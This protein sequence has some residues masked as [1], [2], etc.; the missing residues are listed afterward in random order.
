VTQSANQT[1]PLPGQGVRTAMLCCLVAMLDGLDMQMISFL[2]VA[3]MR[4]LGTSVV[5]FGLVFSAGLLGA[6]MGGLV[7]GPLSDLFGRRIVIIISTALFGTFALVT[8]A[9]GSS[10][11]LIALRFLTG[12][13]LGGALPNILALTAEYSPQNRRSMMVSLMI[14]GFPLGAVF[15]GIA[16]SALLDHQLGWRVIMF[17]GGL[18]PLI[19]IPILLWK[20]PESSEFL[21]TINSTTSR[22]RDANSRIKISQLV[23]SLPVVRLLRKDIRSITLLLWVAFFCILLLVYLLINWM[24]L[25]LSRSGLPENSAL[26]FVALL[27]F[28]GI[29]GSLGIA[30]QLDRRNGGHGLPIAMLIGCGAVAMLGFSLEP[31]SLLIAAIAVAG[32][33]VLGSQVGLNA[34]AT[35]IY[36]AEFRSTGV[37]W[38]LSVG[39][40]GSIVGPLVGSFLIQHL[41]LGALFIWSA[42]PALVAAICIYAVERLHRNSTEPVP[43]PTVVAIN[44]SLREQSVGLS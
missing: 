42:L 4:D 1:T 11:Q 9:A 15:G 18:L 31:I 44:E 37:G 3:I 38:A 27:N 19:F 23:R 8:A 35:R 14:C 32:I 22:R 25:L 33:G 36:P 29:V 34:L 2:T 40:L 41:S 20:L 16:T 21:D 26:R 12:L 30:W 39:R 5:E 7:F 13:G 28:A 17:I 43:E 10:G 24:P 6:M